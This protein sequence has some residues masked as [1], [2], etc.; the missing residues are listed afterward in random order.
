MES[1]V[2]T[3]SQVTLKV[4]MLNAREKELEDQAQNLLEQEKMIAALTV[5]KNPRTN[6]KVVT[7]FPWR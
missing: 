4:E 2:V 6:K 1:R 7:I 3:F 5:R